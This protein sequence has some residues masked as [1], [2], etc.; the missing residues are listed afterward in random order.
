MTSELRP[1][2][3][4][5]YV[6]VIDEPKFSQLDFIERYGYL[7]HVYAPGVKFMVTLD[8]SAFNYRAFI[9][10][11]VYVERLHNWYRDYSKYIVPLRRW[12]REFWIYSHAGSFQTQTP[13]Y[14]IDKPLTDVRAHGWFAYQTKASGLL[15]YSL[16]RWA[17]PYPRHLAVPGSVRKA[18]VD[19]PCFERQDCLGQ[20]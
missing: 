10:V 7:S 15:Y 3:S 5:A 13:N 1:W 20:R 17:A 6:Y 8:P 16:N 19:G 9:N 12:G 14:L 2:A 18:A 11:D 4:K